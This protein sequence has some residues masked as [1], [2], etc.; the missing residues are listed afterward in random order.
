MSLT[1]VSRPSG[2]SA[3]EKLEKRSR[4]IKNYLK[5]EKMNVEDIT[6]VG[7]DEQKQGFCLAWPSVKTGLEMLAGIVKNPIAQGAIR[8][9]IVAGNT[10]AGRICG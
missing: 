1:H 2:N 8:L 4:E 3:S 10:V 5:M 9:V 7:S 6:L